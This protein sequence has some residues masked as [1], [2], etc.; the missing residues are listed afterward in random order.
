LTLN[1]GNP[2]ESIEVSLDITH[3][4]AGDL[5]ISLEDPDGG[6]VIL[7]DRMGN[8]ASTFG[9]NGDD[10]VL[11]FSDLA[12]NTA[13][14]LEGAC[15]NLPAAS[16]SYQPV[17][18]LS[19]FSGVSGNGTWTLIIE[20]LAGGDGGSLNGWSMTACTSGATLPV[21]L[22]H[23]TGT[24]M[25]CSYS[26]D[27]SVAREENFSHYEVERSTDGRSFLTFSRVEGGRGTYSLADNSA[28]GRAYYRLKMVDL[29]GTY[30]YSNLLTAETECN[31]NSLITLFPNPVGKFRALQLEFAEPLTTATTFTVFGAD[32]RRL[33]ARSAVETAGRTATLDVGD[34]PTGTYFLRVV[35]GGEAEVR[36][37]VVM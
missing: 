7:V 8:P 3:T 12:P 2:L 19:A 15:G 5:R 4:Y 27:W 34:L 28:K 1:Q 16:G 29:D 9:C 14:D 26:L 30:A 18:A 6:T 33:L 37:F 11:T 35:S 23:F 20:D 10:L 24:A 13:A 31:R 36:S 17:E 25:D 32:G 22:T 21:A